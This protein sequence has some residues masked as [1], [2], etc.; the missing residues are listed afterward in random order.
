MLFHIIIIIKLVYLAV[1]IPVELEIPEKVLEMIKIEQANL[2]NFD[3]DEEVE[4]HEEN[5]L[6]NDDTEIKPVE[7]D[8]SDIKEKIEQDPKPSRSVLNL[9]SKF[10]I[11]I[12]KPHD[13]L[14]T[15]SNYTELVSEIEKC[16]E[17]H[18]EIE[19]QEKAQKKP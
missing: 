9:C 16:I 17:L 12:M 1:D 14:R 15:D 18:K 5:L 6:N 4:Y 19:K 10:L 7:F 13:I 2:S 3:Y 8:L 11:N